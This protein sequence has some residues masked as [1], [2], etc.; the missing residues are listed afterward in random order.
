[1]SDLSDHWNA[2]YDGAIAE[3]LTWYEPVPEAGLRL[4]DQAGLPRGSAVVDVGAGAS[5]MP[6]ALA[7]RG[8]DVTVMDLSEAA[9]AGARVRLPQARFVVG[10]VLAWEPDRAYALWHD[11]AV[12]HFLTEAEQRDAYRAILAKAVPVGGAVVIATFAEDGP[13]KC[14]GLPVRRYSYDALVAEFAD[15]CAP[16]DGV[17]HEHITPKG[18][19]Q[20]FIYALLRRV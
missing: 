14:S 15:I 8:F 3:T 13:E 16:E 12:F 7:A 4:V 10:D 9:L 17:R 2:R 20:P 18:T 11:R 1:M 5:S 19:V 6:D